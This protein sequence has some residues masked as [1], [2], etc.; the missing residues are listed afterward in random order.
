MLAL[1][2]A[3]AASSLQPGAVQ[4]VQEVDGRIA[5]QVRF[6]DLNLNSEAGTSRMHQR[7][8]IAVRAACPQEN[9]LQLALRAEIAECRARAFDQGLAQVDHII[10]ARSGR[11]RQAGAGDTRIGAK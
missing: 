8:R 7:L 3:I 10:A 5:V 11:G 9:G 2:S 4:N 1:L 6:D